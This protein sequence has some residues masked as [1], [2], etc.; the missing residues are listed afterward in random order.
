[1]HL[2]NMHGWDDNETVVINPKDLVD[3]ASLVK[4]AVDAIKAISS[5]LSNRRLK[6]KEKEQIE[7]EAKKLLS[8]ATGDDIDTYVATPRKAAIDARMG[9][10]KRRPV[11][12]SGPPKKRHPKR[13][14]SGTKKITKR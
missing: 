5:A 13:K 12:G 6:K 7:H 9:A 2:T 14:A 10:V 8:L 4:T 11:R 1:M 3:S